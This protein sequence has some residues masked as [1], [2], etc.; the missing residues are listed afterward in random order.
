VLRGHQD[1]ARAVAFSP[2]GQHLLSGG[3]DSTARLWDL[4][5]SGRQRVLAGHQRVV[6]HVTASPD[7]R[8]LATSGNNATTRVWA[9]DHAG[10]P[11]A[12]HRPRQDRRLSISVA[13]LLTARPLPGATFAELDDA[14]IDLRSGDHRRSWGDFLNADPHRSYHQVNPDRI[15]NSTNHSNAG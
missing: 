6:W 4:D 9:T 12:L 10:A 15:P 1:L 5:G 8:S 14:E 13:R 11:L 3:N 7:G 2:D